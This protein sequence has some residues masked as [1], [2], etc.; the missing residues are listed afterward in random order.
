MPVPAGG[1]TLGRIGE[2]LDFYGPETMLLVGGSLLLA[3]ERLAE[4]TAGFTAAVARHS[5]S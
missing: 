2:K 5:Y 1:I 4:E 3:R